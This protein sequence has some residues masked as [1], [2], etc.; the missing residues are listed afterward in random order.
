[1]SP[2]ESTAPEGT[3]VQ[4][5]ENVTGWHRIEGMKVHEK[6]QRGNSKCHQNCHQNQ[7]HTPASRAPARTYS[8]RSPR[9]NRAA[10]V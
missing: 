2:T 7:C 3:K 6:A 10:S 8:I 9:Q 4:A 5:D 1:M